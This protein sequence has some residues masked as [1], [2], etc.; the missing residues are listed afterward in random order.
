MKIVVVGALG[1][2]GSAVA[3]YFKSMGYDVVLNDI[4]KL[5]GVYN[6]LNDCLGDEDFIF[7]C[8][9]TLPKNDG[10]IDTS[11]VEKVTKKI[12]GV[13][14]D[15]QYNPNV[16]Y[17][18]TIVPGTTRK[19]VNILRD[20]CPE[21]KVAFNPEFLRQNYSLEDM[22]KPSRIVVGSDDM[23]FT[24]KVMALYDNTE[25]PKYGLPSYE[26]AE[27]IKYYTNCYYAAR[28]SFF[29]QM[30]LLADHY[31]CDHD[32]LVNAVV[33]DPTVGVHGSNPTGQSFGGACLVKD[34]SA[35]LKH[36]EDI[37]VYSK[38]LISI[39]KINDLYKNRENNGNLSEWV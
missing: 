9:P 2:V 4:V 32:R 11:I 3:V 24:S 5:D 34:L 33:Q 35:I 16:I 20:M 19:M 7:V 38:F 17:K 27:L 26:D 21:V 31:G 6:D 39:Q 29:N 36:T 30:K 28:I 14:H 15:K 22:M 12:A 25:A 37:G 13:A 23:I 10:S 1:V 18:S 8:V